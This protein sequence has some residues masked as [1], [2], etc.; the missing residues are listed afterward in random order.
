MI[1]CLAV[2]CGAVFTCGEPV[3]EAQLLAV[4]YAAKGGYGASILAS[5]YFGTP[6]IQAKGYVT[7][8]SL[9]PVR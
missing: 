3:A 8:N 7:T 6:P 4:P 5:G 2:A 9:P 1:P